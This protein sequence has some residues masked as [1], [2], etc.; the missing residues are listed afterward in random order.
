MSLNL[1][2]CSDFFAEKVVDET[3][4]D[5]LK[6]ATQKIIYRPRG[7]EAIFMHLNKNNAEIACQIC[8][9]SRG[10]TAHQLHFLS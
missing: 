6:M 3:E 9:F 5:T 2:V 10:G 4:I 1:L 8:G 7:W